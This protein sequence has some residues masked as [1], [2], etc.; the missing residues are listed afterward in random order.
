ATE[1]YTLSLH[2]ALPI[3][4]VAT[5]SDEGAVTHRT[6]Y[7]SPAMA[8]WTARSRQTPIRPGPGTTMYRLIHGEDC[9]QIEDATAD[10]VYR[11]GE[12]SEEHTSELQSQSNLV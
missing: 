10:E 12:R 8:E 6:N 3:C 1:T 11:R 4:G 7:G 2:D 9:V 5:I